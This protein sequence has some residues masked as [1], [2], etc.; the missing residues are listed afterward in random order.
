MEKS[1]SICKGL[2]YAYII[3]LVCLLVYNLLLTFTSMSADSITVAT[4]TITTAS[5]AFGGFYASMKIKEKGLL[6]GVLV[7]LL[8]IVCLMVV[9]FLAKDSF[10]FEVTMMYKILLVSIAGGIGGVLGVNFK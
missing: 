10:M 3:T 2:G 4:S 6:Y 9:V 5:S 1:S 8:Y 7:G